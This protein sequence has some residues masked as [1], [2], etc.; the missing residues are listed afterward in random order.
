MKAIMGAV[1]VAVMVG[2]AGKSSPADQARIDQLAKQNQEMKR[3]LAEASAGIKAAEAMRE[4]MRLE[5]D[6]AITKADQ[7]T[8]AA[9]GLLRAPEATVI[10]Y[11][12]ATP[13][14]PAAPAPVQSAYSEVRRTEPERR[15]QVQAPAPRSAPPT[16]DSGII[17]ACSTQWGSDFRMVEYCQRQQQEAKE[18]LAS[19]ASSPPINDSVMAGIRRD[20]IGQWAGDY[21]MRDYCEKQQIASYQKINLR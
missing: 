11:T 19:R 5:R 1:I 9:S 7:I 6:A 2:C 3:Q 8:A 13:V 21:R 10:Q 15:Q 20:C 18:A 17:A 12:A 16:N 14:A 4:A